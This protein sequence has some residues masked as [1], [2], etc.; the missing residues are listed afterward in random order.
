MQTK[1]VS[2]AI[3]ISSDLDVRGRSI[4]YIIL[5]LVEFWARHKITLMPVMDPA[6]AGALDQLVTSIVDALN[7]NPPGPD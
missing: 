3:G 2:R 4:T 5:R 6:V 1:E 7:V